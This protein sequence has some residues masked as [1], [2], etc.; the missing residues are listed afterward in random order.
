MRWFVLAAFAVLLLA[1]SLATALQPCQTGCAEIRVTRVEG[2]SGDDVPLRV[3]F[4]QGEEDGVPGEGNDDVAAV[5]FSVGIPGTGEGEFFGFSDENCLD[6]NG[7]GLPDGVTI[8]DATIRDNFRVVVENVECEGGTCGCAPSRESCLCP[9]DGQGRQDFVNVVVFGPKDLPAQGPVD[10]P[11]LPDSA[12]LLRLSLT[13]F[14]GTD[15]GE[16][17]RVFPMHVFAETDPPE[18]KPQFAANLSIGDLA[19]IDQTADRGPADVSKVSFVD[20][21]ITVLPALDVCPGDCN[22]DTLVQVSELI[23]GVNIALDKTPLSACNP[24]DTNKNDVVAID[25]LVEAVDKS[26]AGCP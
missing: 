20:G 17:P 12:E 23:T 3:T 7:D 6:A 19:A 15:F 9:G 8:P 21:S 10:I 2:R 25:E 11:K 4:T 14:R 24:V 16:L 26:L 1:P 5:A 18:Q 13:I 22:E